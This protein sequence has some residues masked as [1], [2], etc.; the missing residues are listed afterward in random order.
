[1]KQQQN[2]KQKQ[3]QKILVNQE[4]VKN[5]IVFYKDLYPSN[6]VI[7]TDFPGKTV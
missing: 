7:D 1:M 6:G 5:S 2:E 3:K 4:T